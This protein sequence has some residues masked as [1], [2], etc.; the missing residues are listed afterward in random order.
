MVERKPDDQMLTAILK[1]VSDPRRRELLTLLV[2]HGPTRVTDLA[3]HF[4]VSLNAVSKH[5]K[6]LEAAGLVRR[7]TEWREHLI[8]PDMGPVREI[9]RWFQDLRSIWTQRLDALDK[10][11]ET[12]P[13]DE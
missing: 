13:D 10:I 11:L 9:D 5:I 7:R 1:A 4:D 3:R 8:E 6:V 2:Q 12:E